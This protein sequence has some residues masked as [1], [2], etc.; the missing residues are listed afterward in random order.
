MV[1]SCS[2]A[3]GQVLVK[4]ILVFSREWVWVCFGAAFAMV[5]V[6][7][8]WRGIYWLPMMTSTV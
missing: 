5:H 3:H 2:F 4:M 1:F 6:E 7:Y 8:R